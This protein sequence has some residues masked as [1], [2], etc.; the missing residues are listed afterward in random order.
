MPRAISLFA[1]AGGC[2]L[3]FKQAGY[4]IVFATDSGVYPHGDNARQ[5]PVM[6]HHGMTELQA[7]QAA[8][9]TAARLLRWERDLGS[10]A[11]GKLADLVALPLAQGE[12]GLDFTAQP[13]VIQG[14]RLVDRA[15]LLA[16]PLTKIE[17]TKP[18][19]TR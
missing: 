4:D 12:E 11:P 7:I 13:Q 5:F 1:G 19:P 14:G 16:A 15:A 3:G 8:T 17:A 6:L 10:I 2:S 18:T 9:W